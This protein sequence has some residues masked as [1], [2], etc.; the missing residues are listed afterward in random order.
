MSI[1]LAA[2]RAVTSLCKVA[3]E[4]CISWG[5]HCRAHVTSALCPA[6]CQ[7]VDFEVAEGT[8]HHGSRFAFA[9]AGSD[10]LRTIRVAFRIRDNCENVATVS[11]AL[12]KETLRT[13]CF[14]LFY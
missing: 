10:G 3:V 6:R 12:M 1:A 4:V 8:V 14:V 5:A 9:L 7:G 13:F 11:C 2:P